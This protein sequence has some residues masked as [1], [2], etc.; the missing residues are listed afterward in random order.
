MRAVG[1]LGREA[2]H[3]GRERRQQQRRGLGRGRRDVSGRRHPVE[4]LAHRGERPLVGVAAAGHDRGVAD[5]ERENE[6]AGECLGECGRTVRGRRRVPRPD[7][8]DPCG[9][10]DPLGGAEQRRRMREDLAIGVVLADPYG[11]VP[12]LLDPA[13]GGPLVRGRPERDAP[14]PHPHTAELRHEPSLLHHPTV[15]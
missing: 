15:W 10:D 5:A 3:P 12:E 9:D 11:A 8:G 6:A 4:V 7:A 2:H 1:S 13:N 14:E